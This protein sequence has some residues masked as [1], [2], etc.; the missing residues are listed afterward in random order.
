MAQHGKG[1]EKMVKVF[2]FLKRRAEIS[3][4]DFHRHWTAHHG[5]LFV[6][7]TAVRRYVVHYE[8]NHA[9]VAATGLPCLDFDGVS[10]MSFRT[11]DD[12]QSMRADPEYRRVVVSDGETF[13]DASATRVMMTSEEDQY[14]ITM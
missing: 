5:P 7:C 14:E 12:F 11:I 4:D 2:F 3:A 10:V 1:D 13:G 6:T 8:Q 9:G